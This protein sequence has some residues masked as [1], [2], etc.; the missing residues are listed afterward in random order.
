[1]APLGEW[2]FRAVFAVGDLI[3]LPAALYATV[4]G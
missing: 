3:G 2:F 4:S 1:V